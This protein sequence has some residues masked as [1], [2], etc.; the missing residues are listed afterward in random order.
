[1]DRVDPEVLFQERDGERTR[2]DRNKTNLREKHLSTDR[3]KNNFALRIVGCGTTYQLI[4]MNN[5]MWRP[6]R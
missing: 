3:R 4:T 5:R 2:A 6:S 1:V